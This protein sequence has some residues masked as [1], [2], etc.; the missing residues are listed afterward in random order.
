MAHFHLAHDPAEIDILALRR[1]VALRIGDKLNL[2]KLSL[3]P[4]A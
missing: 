3:W 2:I 4:R 1:G